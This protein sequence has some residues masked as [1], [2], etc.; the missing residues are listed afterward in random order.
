MSHFEDLVRRKA[1]LRALLLAR[2]RAAPGPAAAVAVADRLL[3]EIDVPQGAVVSGYWPLAGELDPRPCLHRLAARGHPLALPR[4]QGQGQPLAFHPWR[5]DDPLTLGRFG[6]MQPDPTQPL[7]TPDVLLV[8]LLGFDRRGHRLGYGK[9]YYDRTLRALRE[10]GATPLAIGLAFAL[11]EVS[12]V[13]IGPAD[14]PLDAVVT[15]RASHRFPPPPD[16]VT[17]HAGPA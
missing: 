4:M 2:R 9:G 11:Q 14:Q 8:P 10:G 17:A 13:P 6:V 7:V 12:E 15:E 5:R 3:H 1:E 16:R